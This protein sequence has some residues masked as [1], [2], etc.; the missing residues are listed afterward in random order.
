M[1]LFRNV[2]ALG[3][4]TSQVSAVC[5]ATFRAALT[6]AENNWSADT[7]ISFPDDEDAFLAATRRWSPYKP[8]T[9][10]AAVTVANENDI[11][12]AVKLAR[13]HDIPFLA[14][15][16]RHGYG[17]TMGELE[18]GLSIDLSQLTSAVVDKEAATLTVGGG[19][20]AHHIL[21]PVN[22]AGFEMQVGGCS[23]PGLVGV[24]IGAGA[25]HWQ[26]VHGLVLDALLHVRL[27]TAEGEIVEASKDINPDLFWA[28]RGAGANFGIIAEATYQLSPQTNNDE[29]LIVDIAYPASTNVSYY[30]A[31]EKLIANQ[32]P[33]LSHVSVTLWNFT[34]SAPIVVGNFLYFGPKEEG[35]ALL[36]P[37]YDLDP[38]FSAESVVSWAKVYDTALLGSDA[39][40]CLPGLVHSPYGSVMKNIS[41]PTMIRSFERM[42]KFY[43]DYPAGRMTSATYQRAGNEATLA[44]PEES[45]AYPWRDAEAYQ[46]VLLTFPPG[47]TVTEAA[48]HQLGRE[49]RDDYAATSG[50]GGLAVYVNTAQGDET[51]EQRYGAHKLPRLA[52]LKAEWDPDNVFRFHHALPTSYPAAAIPAHQDDL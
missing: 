34:F 5:D 33:N 6:A 25:N 47:D 24:T 13:A 39:M 37:F 46:Y 9:F 48:A 8:P 38:F 7:T 4:L 52:S 3:L 27:I 1:G 14:T 10:S 18:L 12:T 32:P 51:L 26:G 50:Y 43:T 44:I 2:V 28:I 16:G 49:I 22:E 42:A 40:N 31:I 36:Q 17:S 19:A 29:I 30:N 23:C 45:T 15:G 35:M 11:A 20:R 41:V 21:K